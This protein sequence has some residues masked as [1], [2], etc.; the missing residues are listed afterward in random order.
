MSEGTYP[1][2]RLV[3]HPAVAHRLAELRDRATGSDRFREL[4]GQLAAFV[5]YEALRDMVT[6]PVEVLTPM[7]TAAERRISETILVV[8][9][10]RAGLAMVPGVQAVAPG[11]EVAHLGMRR[12]ES[13]LM[14]ST[15]LDGLPEDLGGR[16][17]VVCDPMLATGGSLSAACRLVSARGPRRL[18]ALCVVA[19]VQGLT[20]FHQEFPSVGVAYAALDSSLDERGFILPGLGDAGDRLF[21]PPT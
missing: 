13:T 1:N 18:Q 15:Y 9:V 3:E 21:G 4:M 20:R 7:G 6:E 2:D 16:R 11:T 19:A 10:L 8:P 5:A 17:V 12:D 14:A